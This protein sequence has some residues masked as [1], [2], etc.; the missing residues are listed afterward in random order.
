MQRIFH[1]HEW[2]VE[3]KL[4]SLATLIFNIQCLMK[5]ISSSHQ[6]QS[7][8]TREFCYLQRKIII[9]CNW[10]SLGRVS[11]KSLPNNNSTK[12][13]VSSTDFSPHRMKKFIQL[14]KRFFSIEFRRNFL[15]GAKFEEEEK[16]REIVSLTSAMGKLCKEKKY[17]FVWFHTKKKTRFLFYYLHSTH[18]LSSIEYQWY[19][20]EYMPTS[21]LLFLSI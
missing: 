16:G 5:S 15:N 14:A 17:H 13:L 2:D 4:L 19:S 9:D 8:L 11:L 3:Q 1:S 10:Y 12:I 6:S 21:Y 7:N 18:F 20:N